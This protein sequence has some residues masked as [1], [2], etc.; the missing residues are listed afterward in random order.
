MEDAGTEA[1]AVARVTELILAT[2]HSRRAMRRRR[3]KIFSARS[4]PSGLIRLRN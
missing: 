2:K 1:A 3:D 4:N